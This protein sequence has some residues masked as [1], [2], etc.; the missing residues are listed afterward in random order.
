[1]ATTLEFAVM[2]GASCISSRQEANRFSAPNGWDEKIKETT[3]QLPDLLKMIFNTDLFACRTDPTN[4]QHPMLLD[5]R[6]HHPAGGMGGIAVG[7][8]R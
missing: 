5:H 4:I 6:V 1:M 3:G 7:A 8:R 2:A